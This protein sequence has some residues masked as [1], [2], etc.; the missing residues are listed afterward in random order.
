MR[1][2]L[3]FFVF[4]L[5]A[6]CRQQEA[7]RPINPKPSTTIIK[8][9]VEE[10]KVL[11]EIENKKIENYI[12]QDPKTVYI[13]SASGFWYTYLHKIEE[14]VPSPKFEELAIISYD[15]KDL[16]RET[17][18]SSEELGL[19]NYIVDRS[20]FIPALQQ[21]IKLMKI[22]EVV[23]F[24]IPSYR[25]YGISGDGNKIGINQSIISTVKLINI[26]K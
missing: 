16:S 17:I 26:I 22:G 7:R 23:T 25:A 9:M 20:D 4:L 2:S 5:F 3:F 6:C 18:Y 14:D 21:G 11:N 10:S 1:N 8:T 13:N 12:K 24:V 19:K 15:I